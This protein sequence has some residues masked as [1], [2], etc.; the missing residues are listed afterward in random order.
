MEKYKA[1]FIN[2][3][4]KLNDGTYLNIEISF[5]NVTEDGADVI[6]QNI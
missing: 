5:E 2:E 6:I 4:P 1:Y 3:E